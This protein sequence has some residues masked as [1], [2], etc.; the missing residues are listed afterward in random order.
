MN[1]SPG[2]HLCVRSERR[3]SLGFVVSCNEGSYFM[4]GTMLQW[5][6]TTDTPHS[7]YQHLLWLDRRHDAITRRFNHCNWHVLVSSQVRRVCG[8]PHPLHPDFRWDYLITLWFEA[9]FMRGTL[10]IRWSL[11]RLFP[12]TLNTRTQPNRSLTSS[13]VI[14]LWGL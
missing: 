6:L 5:Y 14:S 8:L 10:R 12:R 4:Q 2:I 9:E 1:V 13:P 3:S 7:T 11:V